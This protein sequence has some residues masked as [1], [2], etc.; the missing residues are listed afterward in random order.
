VFYP[1]AYHT[2]RAIRMYYFENLNLGT[3]KGELLESTCYL[4]IL[5]ALIIASCACSSCLLA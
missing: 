2:D 5:G 1:E 3:I 4:H